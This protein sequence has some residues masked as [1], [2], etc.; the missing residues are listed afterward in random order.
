[1]GRAYSERFI[2]V[3]GPAKTY[4]YN[5]PVGQRAIIKGLVL[6]NYDTV[7]QTAALRVA[8]V[9]VWIWSLPGGGQAVHEDT[10]VVVYAGEAITLATAGPSMNGAISGYLLSA[11]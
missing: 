6:A 10:M 4:T 9:T 3:F 8:G 11:V 5:V 1:M 2:L 7:P